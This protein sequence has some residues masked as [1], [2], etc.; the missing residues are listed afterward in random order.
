MGS[1]KFESIRGGILYQADTSRA[2][3]PTIGLG[4]EACLRSRSR[5]RT[6]HS[7]QAHQ[8]D[9][10]KDTPPNYIN[11][12]TRGAPSHPTS[13]QPTGSNRSS[14]SRTAATAAAVYN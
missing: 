10:G 3:G 5:R 14:Q 4:R 2:M 13:F 8:Y 7:R 6:L 12:L 9:R 11:L 1:C